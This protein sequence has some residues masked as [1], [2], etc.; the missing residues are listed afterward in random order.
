MWVK[1]RKKR[2]EGEGKREREKNIGLFLK[3]DE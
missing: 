3:K 2:R 1:I